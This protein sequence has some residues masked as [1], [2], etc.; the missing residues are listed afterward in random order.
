MPNYVLFDDVKWKN[1]FPLTHTRSTADIRC[2]ILTIKEKWE[3]YLQNKTYI[4]TQTYL[5]D[6]YEFDNSIQ[7]CIYINSRVLP[8]PS[9]VAT[10]KDLPINSELFHEDG[11]L[12]AYR[13]SDCIKMDR[14][15]QIKEDNNYAELNCSILKNYWD[16]FLLNHQEIQS[17]FDCLT[18]GRISQEI[19]SYVQCKSPENIFIEEDAVLDFCILN[20]EHGKIYIGKSAHIMDGAIVRGSAAICDNAVI[21]MGTKIYE[22]TTIGPYC[23]IGGEVSNVVFHSYSN[24][25]HDGYL[26]NAIIGAWC[27][28]GADT[29]CSNL[30]NDYGHIQVWSEAENK[31]IDTGQQFVGLF[32]G[33]HSKCAINT[34][35]NTG[36]I[37]GVCCN[38][39]GAGFPPT[40]IPS[41][42]WGWSEKMITHR[43][44]KSIA[45]NNRMMERR[46]LSLSDAEINVLHHIFENTQNLRK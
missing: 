18:K 14:L 10:I 29:N 5:Q 30:K 27:N 40:F 3:H 38:V 39:F 8:N 45:A 32:M 37:V 15:L 25:G 13:S 26:G 9:V 17:D 6:L 24:K 1:F 43:I 28:L 19:P 23:K 21:K 20:A 41:F 12:I 33:D 42:S 34:M 2:G 7:D 44:D 16:I 31:K 22:H 36:T 4:L 35:F 46:R 11:S